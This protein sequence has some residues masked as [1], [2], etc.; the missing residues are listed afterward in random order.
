MKKLVVLLLLLGVASSALAAANQW[1]S[2][3]TTTNWF[4]PFNWSLSSVPNSTTDNVILYQS[5][6]VAPGPVLLSG[7]SAVAYDLLVCG[8]ATP[9]P[10]V[11]QTL[12][13]KPGASLA[14]TTFLIVSGNG[15][16]LR[17]GDLIMQGGTVNVGTEFAVGRSSAT[18]GSAQKGWLHMTGG[19][20]NVVGNFNIARYPNS[21]G[22]VEL[23]GGTISTQWF[24]MLPGGGTG[25]AQ[26]DIKNDGKLIISGDAR[27]KIAGY[28]ASNWITGTGLQY[29]YDITTPLKTTVFVPEPATLCLLAIGALGLIRR[30]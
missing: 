18:S 22:W 14:T 1:R 10:I 30:K 2:T 9:T 21:S 7:Q 20:I 13:I 26:L 3:N 25:V 4:D 5:S 27:T 19:T 16:T 6:G 15:T 11:A 24:D 8:N 12:T 23:Y 28:I 29:D 17:Y